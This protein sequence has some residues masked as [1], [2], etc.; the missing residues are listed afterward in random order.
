MAKHIPNSTDKYV[1]S[2]VRLRRMMLGMSQGALADA[3]GITFQQVQKYEKA[4]NRISSSRLQQAAHI[5]Q[6]PVSFFFDDG[7]QSNKAG[8]Q[9]AP[10]Y[11]AAFLGSADGLALIKA[12]TAIKDAKL[13]R[14]IVELVKGIE[15]NN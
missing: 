12:F 1:G 11:V 10:E 4:A 15:A 7:P 3:L 8:Q 5:L 14:S 6:V 2:R 9:P 13:R